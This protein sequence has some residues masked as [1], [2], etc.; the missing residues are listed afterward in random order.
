MNEQPPNIFKSEIINVQRTYDDEGYIKD[1]ISELVFDIDRYGWNINGEE[2]KKHETY[3][4]S[5]LFCTD[6]TSE[7]EFR[8]PGL[9]NL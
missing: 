7:N 4:F 8:K 9:V 5:D 2:V 6:P 3:T 1:K